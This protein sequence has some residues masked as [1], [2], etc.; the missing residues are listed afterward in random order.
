M[1]DMHD[2]ELDHMKKLH[3][4]EMEKERQ[5]LSKKKFGG[6]NKKNALLKLQQ[7]HDEELKAMKDKHK[8]DEEDMHLGFETEKTINHAIQEEQ[9][10]QEHD[11][12]F[13][14]NI[15]LHNLGF[16]GHDATEANSPED[17]HDDFS[18]AL[19]AMG[20]DPNDMT[21]ME[22]LS[23]GLGL[24]DGDEHQAMQHHEFEGLLAQLEQTHN[25][26]GG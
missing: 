12:V 21:G 9:E 5:K 1:K 17:A 7:Q 15:G 14:D 16:D 11:K 10:R 3:D 8:E 19:A 23:L 25:E 4:Q 13:D 6:R 2:V 18:A 20:H 24:D 22:D 26:G